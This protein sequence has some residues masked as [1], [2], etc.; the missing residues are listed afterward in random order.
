MTALERLRMTGIRRIG[1]SRRG[2]RYRSPASARLRAADRDRIEKLRIP[3]A[4]TEVSISPSAGATLQAIGRDAAGRWQYRYHERHVRRQNARKYHRVLSFGA[5]LPRMRRQVARDLGQPGLPRQKVLACVIR[6]LGAC[7]IRPGSREYAAHGSYGL[8]TL[9]RR[10]L[11]VSGDL[12][13]F[14]FPG[15]S[16]KRQVTELRDRRV[17][18]V[19]RRCLALPGR[20]AFKWA[21]GDGTIQEL[22]RQHINDYIKDIMG[23]EFSAKDFRTW[24]GTLVCAAVLA[25]EG[26]PHAESRTAKKRR[27]VAAIKETASKL[28]NTPAV[29][30]SAY[31]APGVLEAFAA[32]QVSDGSPA[33]IDTVVTRV[34]PDLHPV[35]KAVLK[36]L[37]PSATA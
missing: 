10:H 5:A 28:G 17:A 12:V 1:S 36:V 18:S 11:S 16:G 4:W 8:A 9:R 21:N 13:R 27:I 23:P 25:R 2:F 7:F 20:Q 32:G 37:S 33:D 34:E 14:D 6:I 22:R 35:E 15:K 24:A 31:V 19:V 29:C 30:R 26:A 3:P